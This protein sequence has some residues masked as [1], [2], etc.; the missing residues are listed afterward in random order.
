MEN[1]DLKERN[2]KRHVNFTDDSD[3]ITE[4]SEG[5]VNIAEWTKGDKKPLVCSWL[6]PK[7]PPQSENTY[8]FDTTKCDRIFDLLLQ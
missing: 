5:E 3:E 7:K 8:T 6:A 4:S 1:R 2:G